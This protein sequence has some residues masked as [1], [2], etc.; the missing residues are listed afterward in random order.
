MSSSVFSETIEI[1]VP[2]KICMC[3]SIDRGRGTV[4]VQILRQPE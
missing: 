2:S 1:V 4:E 3:C